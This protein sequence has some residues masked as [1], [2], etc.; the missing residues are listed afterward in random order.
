MHVNRSPDVDI[1]ESIIDK[2][3][4]EKIK[5]YHLYLSVQLESYLYF[6]N[7]K[8]SFEIC[9]GRPNIYQSDIFLPPALFLLDMEMH[10]NE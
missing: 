1:Y 3:F 8:T 9:S 6:A 10:I 5:F 4:R 7:W 2:V